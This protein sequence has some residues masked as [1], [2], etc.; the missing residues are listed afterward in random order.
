MIRIDLGRDSKKSGEKIRKVAAQLKL[1]Q[2]YNELLAK[3]DNDVNRL[4]AF[5]VSIGVAVLPYLF[6][7]EYERVVTASYERQYR[8][9]DKELKVLEAEV[10]SL[11]PFKQELDS[12]EAQKAQVSQ[13]LAVIRSLVDTRGTP[14]TTLDAVAQALPEG[15]WLESLSFDSSDKMLDKVALEGRS[16]SNEDISD[17]VDR[18]STSSYLKNVRIRSVE[19]TGD[20]ALGI[21]NF[22]IDLDGS[23]GGLAIRDLGS[24]K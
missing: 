12:Y 4:V 13:R 2:P 3:F 20:P 15:V 17:F 16:L 24:N 22:G 1:E 23:R 10:A 6:A 5:V 19:S 9:A 11:M 8:A 14:V 18:L 7:V 21:K